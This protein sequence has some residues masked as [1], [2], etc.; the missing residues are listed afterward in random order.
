M[1][2]FTISILI[3]MGGCQNI[4]DIF[5]FPNGAPVIISKPIVYIEEN[6]FYIYQVEANDPDGDT[7]TYLLTLKAE[8][9]D[10]DNEKGLIT[11]RPTSEQLGIHKV[12][13]EVSDGKQSVIQSFEIEVINVNEPLQI[14]S[15]SPINLN[16]EIN[17]GDSIKFK[18]QANDVDLNSTLV[19]RWFLEGILA[20]SSSVESN[21]S[22]SS[23]QYVS[24]YGDYGTKT[25]KVIISDGE[26]SDNVQ[27]IINIKDIVPPTKP[28]LNSFITPTNTSLQTLSGT[29]EEN[30]SIWI[31][32][33]EVIP[34]NSSSE[35]LYSYNL[36]EGINNIIIISRDAANNESY[37]IIIVIECDMNIYVNTENSS[38][39]EEGTK[40]HPF[41][42]ITEGLEIVAVGKTV[43]VNSGIYNEQL[44]I[45]KGIKLQGAGKE[46]TFIDGEGYTGNLIDIRADDVTISGFT[47]D[48]RAVTD[49]GIYCD[50]FSFIEISENIIQR[51]RD[52]GI[53]YK[54]IS[55]DYSVGIH[56]Y[57]NEICFNLKSGIK[58]TDEGSG[59]VE[60]N[61][62]RNNNYGI[63]VC[64]DASFEIKMN[65]ILDNSDSG[66]F[67]QDNSSLLIWGNEIRGNGY[68]IRVG[69]LNSDNTNPDIGGGTKGGI[70][71][72]NITGNITYGINN[73]TSHNIM[74]QNNWWG[75][76]AGPK[77]PG[78]QNNATI[79]SDWAYW[80]NQ[81]GNII[82]LPYLTEAQS[83]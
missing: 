80:S 2:L 10:I 52:S 69:K 75:D 72:N 42:T 60:S 82:F 56:V 71:Q 81:N 17:E 3:L 59:I 64:N 21:D 15:Y 31:N 83:F 68:G 4:K 13:V 51:H 70:G 33:T 20:L 34:I 45:N 41:N 77:Y 28:T 43:I 22:K 40:I 78:N 19:Y 66:I 6:N 76:S 38:G 24:K 30:S 53:F 48:G 46:S 62:I 49:I 44:V 37:P 32:G 73:R 29:K 5:H 63:Q 11:W 26:F 23:W 57:S 1:F 9:M 25:V 14:I 50:S 47:I 36:S 18:V 54:R 67:C 61:I 79:S 35:W 58:V 55:D 7:L 12:I 65:N 27:W 74:A 8:G 39:I 16:V